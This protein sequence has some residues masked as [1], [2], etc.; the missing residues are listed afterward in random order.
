MRASCRCGRVA[1]R[2]S[3]EP[4]HLAYCHCIDCRRA[5][6]APVAAL[7][8]FRDEDLVLEAAAPE[9]YSEREGVE[10]LFCAVCGSPLGYRDARLPSETYLAIVAFGDED[11]ARMAP[12]RHS[13]AGGRMPWFDTTD[14]HPRHAATSRPRAAPGDG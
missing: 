13:F 9:T 7:A 10:R 12:D 5:T 14:D 3:A 8:G 1:W 4:M 2:V 6:G 11:A